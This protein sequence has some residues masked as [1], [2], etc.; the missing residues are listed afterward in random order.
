MSKMLETLNT[1][2]NTWHNVLLFKSAEEARKAD[3]GLM[4]E[5]EEGV[6]YGIRSKN[7][8]YTWDMVGF[9]PYSEQLYEKY[10]KNAV[11][12]LAEKR[13]YSSASRE[14]TDGIKVTVLGGEMS[15]DEVKAYV[16]RA[17]EIYPERDIQ[18]ME[19]SIID[20]KDIEIEYHYGTIPFERIRRVT[21][22]LAGTLDRF[23][24]AKQA[25]VRDRVKHEISQQDFED[26]YI[27]DGSDANMDMEM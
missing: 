23:N 17:K 15:T 7:D 11:E 20:E 3:M 26:V 5:D 19:I 27:K 21:G 24:N 4:Y 1:V 10:E 13:M 9:V 18:S 14:M 16:K 6:V 8:I 25:E 2:R 22:Y 12:S